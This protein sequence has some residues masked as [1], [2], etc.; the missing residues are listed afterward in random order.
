MGKKK[1]KKVKKESTITELLNILNKSILKKEQFTNK[2]GIYN[3]NNLVLPSSNKDIE[4]RIRVIQLLYENSSGLKNSKYDKFKNKNNR[5]LILSDQP[6]F[7]YSS[8]KK[9]IF[10]FLTNNKKEYNDVL[11]YDPSKHKSS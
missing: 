10:N 2:N 7:L 6:I 5:H 4:K 3:Y 11:T 8:D 9:Q 1:K